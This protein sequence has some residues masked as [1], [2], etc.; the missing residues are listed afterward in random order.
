MRFSFAGGILIYGAVL[1][2]LL[3][4]A[5]AL[6]YWLESR[7]VTVQ[8][9]AVYEAPQEIF[10]QS[11]AL[12]HDDSNSSHASL[13]YGARTFSEARSLI[14]SGVGLAS[15]D[16]RS[17]LRA[18]ARAC[19]GYEPTLLPENWRS[20]LRY[21][22]V[23]GRGHAMRSLQMVVYFQSVYCD[24]VQPSSASAGMDEF[25]G[26]I[27][28]LAAETSDQDTLEF[29][30]LMAPLWNRGSSDARDL[31][32]DGFGSLASRTGSPAIFSEALGIVMSRNS[33]S[34]GGS[35]HT[36]LLS[37]DQEVRRARAVAISLARCEIFNAC[38]PMGLAVMVQCAPYRCP[39]DGTLRSYYASQ[40]S[41]SVME[42]AEAMKRDIV[43][44]RRQ[45]RN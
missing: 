42:A 35:I 12:G 33:D 43:E 6:Y 28:I 3:V 25:L 17:L 5:I 44:W 34:F 39:P 1:S 22:A 9:L 41:D 20:S 19:D 13:V 15:Y 11:R 16:G 32:L 8:P 38:P 40:Y 7:P 31:D 21:P 37:G 27:E 45:S 4:G 26:Q 14:E 36:G 2:A 10:E 30:S 24:G 29:I 23:E 18:S